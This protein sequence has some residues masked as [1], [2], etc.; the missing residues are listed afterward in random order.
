MPYYYPV[1]RI[2]VG[3][4]TMYNSSKVFSSEIKADTALKWVTEW[5]Q[6]TKIWEWQITKEALQKKN[7]D[8]TST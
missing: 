3:Y 1:Y 4:E 7:L 6:T 8:S 5:E 2:T